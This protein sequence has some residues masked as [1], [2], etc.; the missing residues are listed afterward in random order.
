VIP[1]VRTVFAVAILVGTLVVAPAAGARNRAPSVLRHTRAHVAVIGGQSVQAGTFPWMAYVLDFRGNEV[2]QCSGTVVA[3]DLVLT[4]GHC[5]EDMQTGVVNEASGYRIITGNVDWAAPAAERQVSGVTRVIACPCFDRHTL[6]GDVALLQLSTPTT[7]PVVTL[8]SSPRGGTGALMA[9]WGKTYSKQDSPV[10][11]LQWARTVVQGPEWCEREASL[12]SP[13]SNVCTID[14]SAHQTGVCNG[15][16]GGPLLEAEPSAAGGMVQ[17][18]VASHGFVE[19]A[20]TSPSVFTRADAVSAWVRG[21]AQVLASAPP[22]SAP[23]SAN[24]V[25]APT[26]A[27]VASSR[28]VTLGRG[29]ISLVLTCD[30]EGGVCT[31][32]AEAI[33]IA[34][35]RLIARRNG[36]WMVSTRIL[37][38]RLANVVF[39]IAPGTSTSV[40]SSLSAEGQTLLARLGG[41]PLDVILS[42]QGV[43]H[44]VVRLEPRR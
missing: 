15:D 31:G 11:R 4:A 6:V 43:T 18:G 14:P 3:P 24:A 35:E 34:R 27:G 20:T 44:R 13:A 16:S 9:G 26:L 32:N 25:A 23:L 42:G 28:S 7:A 2:G 33:V 29:G 22:V 12:F 36:R 10:E 1:L 39:A 8:A 19:C 5:A 40:R 17:I 21:W 41:G 30:G 37:R 38:V